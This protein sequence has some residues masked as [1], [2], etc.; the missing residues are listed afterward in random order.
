MNIAYLSLY[1]SYILYIVELIA[2][3]S[4]FALMFKRKK[5][6]AARLS[7]SVVAIAAIGLVT[8]I[9]FYFSQSAEWAFFTCGSLYFLINLAFTAIAAHFCFEVDIPQT[10]FIGAAG[11]ALQHSSNNLLSIVQMIVSAAY[12]SLKYP[13][14]YVTLALSLVIAVIINCILFRR[15]KCAPGS[16]ATLYLNNK[17][18]IIATITIFICSILSFNIGNLEGLRQNIVV[19][20]YGVIAALFALYSML[21]Q[22]H[23]R[24]VQHENQVIEELMRHEKR[25]HELSK[26]NIDIINL[27]C[28]DLKHQIGLLEHMSDSQR[29]ESIKVLQSAVMLYD[30][31]IKTGND[32]LDLIFNEKNLI[33]AKYNIRISYLVDGTLLQF[34][35]IADLHSLFGNILDNAIESVITEKEEDKRTINISVTQR[36]NMVHVHAANYCAAAPQFV[37][38]MPVSTKQD[39]N[40][41]GFGT[42]SIKYITEQYG[43]KLICYF[44]DNKYILDILFER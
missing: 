27:K 21:S 24:R 37:D 8:T 11:Y 33:C 3:E 16:F 31:N 25:Q 5:H 34:I 39:K 14:K 32:A 30:S 12:P 26:Q 23:S 36:G 42:K 17:T 29:R 6:F 2:M 19:R 41:H 1:E 15:R 4:A 7:L 18:L 38:G 43:G 40:F 22:L 20:L 9:P 28:H 13:Q 35:N 10:V 44:K